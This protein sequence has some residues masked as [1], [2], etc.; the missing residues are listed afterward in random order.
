MN[1]LHQVGG[2]GSNSYTQAMDVTGAFSFG[3]FVGFWP[4]FFKT[5]FS[6]A[7]FRK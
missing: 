2:N 1:E 3:R 4:W 7:Y 5:P 6:S